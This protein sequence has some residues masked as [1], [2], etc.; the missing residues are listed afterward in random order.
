V[1]DGEGEAAWKLRAKGGK[2]DG[3]TIFG[4][5]ESLRLRMGVTGDAETKYATYRFF[6][7]SSFS[8]FILSSYCSVSFG[9]DMVI[10][11]T[12]IAAIVFIKKDNRNV[13]RVI[14]SVTDFSVSSSPSSQ[15]INARCL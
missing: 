2:L 10:V 15:S 5:T 12:P 13:P 3:V 11:S 7:V 9:I 8:L 4:E 14:L 1:F 6:D